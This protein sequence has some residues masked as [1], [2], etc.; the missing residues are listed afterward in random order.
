MKK[1]III[2]I[3]VVV[4]LL[5]IV[6]VR[7]ASKPTEEMPNDEVSTIN[8]TEVIKPEIVYEEVYTVEPFIVEI[9]INTTEVE[10]IAKTVWGE[11]SGLD[12]FE[13]SA[14]IWCI[15]NRVDAGYGTIEEVITAPNQFHGYSYNFPVTDE[16]RALTEDVL[17]RWYMEKQCIGDVGRTLPSEYLYFYGDG[18][19][20]HFRN[21]YS[22]NYNTWDWD[23]WNPYE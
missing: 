3:C 18:A 11:A 15:L 10:M 8:K 9:E 1:K 12:A 14:V 23:C 22:G 7:V 21:A 4:C 5:I 20:N 2:G 13:Q 16:I 6:G 19:H 17:T